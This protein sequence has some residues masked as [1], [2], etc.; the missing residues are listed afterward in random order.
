MHSHT[1]SQTP[2]DTII[3]RCPRSVTQASHGNTQGHTRGHGH[4]YPLT[5]SQPQ[6]VSDTLGQAIKT[7]NIRHPETTKGIQ[8]TLGCRQTWKDQQDT[9][10]TKTQT[11]RE[12]N[13][14]KPGLSP[15]WRHKLHPSN[16]PRPTTC[17]RGLRPSFWGP[18]PHCLKKPLGVGHGRPLVDQE[19]HSVPSCTELEWVV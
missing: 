14:R 1:L 10:E 11:T 5:L 6:T 17:E 9:L 4:T 8:V 7:Y 12:Y 3:D 13:K 15:K 16:R 2:R 19:S 18:V